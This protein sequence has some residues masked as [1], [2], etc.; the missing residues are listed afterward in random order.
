MPGPSTKYEELARKAAARIEGQRELAEQLTLLPD[1]AAKTPDSGPGAAGDQGARRAR[2]QGKALNQMRQWLAQRGLRLPEDVLADM[3][4][5]ASSDDALI[6]AMRNAERILAWA[7]DGAASVPGAPEGPTLAKRLEVFM[8]VFS[9]QLRAAEALLPYGLA[10]ATPDI[11]NNT[12]VTQ[13]VV[14][15]AQPAAQARPELA[16]DITASAR[17]ITPP[18][19][20]HQIE[21]NQRLAGQRIDRVASDIRTEGASD[22]ND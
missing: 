13:I 4:G 22:G 16:R 3:A 19:M 15:G 12:Q 21:Q 18:P 17:R 7:Q 5:L 10:K 1:E 8:Q 11:T 14:Q 2:G 6:T 20:P 9:V